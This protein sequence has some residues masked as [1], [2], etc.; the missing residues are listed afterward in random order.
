VWN[1]SKLSAA[2][3]IAHGSLQLP[4]REQAWDARMLKCV[5]LTPAP[6]VKGPVWGGELTLELQYAAKVSELLK[7]ALP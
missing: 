5:K 3:E 1:A 6:R 2:Q 4:P 7:H